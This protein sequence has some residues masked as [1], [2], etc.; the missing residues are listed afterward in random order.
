G[1]WVSVFTAGLPLVKQRWALAYF[2]RGFPKGRINVQLNDINY[3]FW[4]QIS[5]SNGL[6][7]GPCDSQYCDQLSSQ[8]CNR[9]FHSQNRKRGCPKSATAPLPYVTSAPSGGIID[10]EILLRPEE[11][12]RHGQRYRARP[13]R[14]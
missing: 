8:S 6:Q 3:I 13:G 11:S 10:T 1:R 7:V 2:P 5:G 4:H 14:G 9:G 12:F